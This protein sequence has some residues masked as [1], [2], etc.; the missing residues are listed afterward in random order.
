[1]NH[2]KFIQGLFL[3]FF[4]IT[5]CCT[6]QD[7][8][9]SE[10]EYEIPA[11]EDLMYEHGILNRLLL[12]FE[13]NIENIDGKGF[14]IDLLKASLD[15]LQSF[16]QDFHER[17]EEDY[18]FPLFHEHKESIPL[19][20]IL[21]EQHIQG[22]EITNRLQTILNSKEITTQNNEEIKVLLQKFVTMYRPHES[23]ED[24]VLFPYVRNFLSEKEFHEL[25]ETFERLEHKFFGV[26]AHQ[27]ILEKI[28]N[29]EKELGIFNIDC[30]TPYIC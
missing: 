4:S 24:T 26:N 3:A 23:R 6:V 2:K 12:I 10:K 8:I 14:S 16:I 18:I 7:L 28:I 21:K 29:I 27:T 15:I 17:L 13:K 9:N 19:I 5:H 25:G 1:M 22:R 20:Q 30:F 11:T